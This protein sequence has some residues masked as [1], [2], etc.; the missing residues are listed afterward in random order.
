MADLRPEASNVFKLP[1]FEISI[2]KTKKNSAPDLKPGNRD[3][4]SLTLC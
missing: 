3:L 2:L 1:L 4:R